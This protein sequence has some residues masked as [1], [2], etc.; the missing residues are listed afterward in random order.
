LYFKQFYLG[1]LAQASYFIGADS[2]AA[3]VD[4]QRDVAQYLDEAAAQGFKIKY[5]IETHLHADF[6]SG[7][8]E[9]AQ[10]TG[11]EIVFGAKA[12]ATIAHRAVK[13]GEEL[14]VGRLRLRVLE[15]PGHTLEGISL[16][17]IDPALSQEPLKA[18]TGDTLFIGDV[19]R[20]DLAGAQGHTPAEMAALLY[21]SLHRKLLALPDDVAVYPAHGAGSL[22]G[23]NISQETT[24]TIGQQRRFN[25]ALQPMPKEQFVQMMTTELPEVPAYF[26]HDV[27]LNRTGATA[28]GNLAPPPALS[29]AEVNQ[30]LQQGSL[31]LD[32]RP[33]DAFGA[34]HI[35][36]ALNIGL[37]GQFASWAGTLIPTA[38]PII[39]VT[40]EFAQVDE[41]VTRLARIGL[42]SVQGYLRDGME[43]WRQAGL[44][45]T[46]IPQISVEEMRQRLLA[47][48]AWQFIDV[49]R[50]AEYRAGHAPAALNAPLSELS[51]SCAQFNRQQATAVICQ[52]G[53]RSSLAASLLARHGFQKLFNVVG[54]TDAWK[55]AGFPLSEN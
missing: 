44:T 36:D 18:L 54:G 27:A 26:T 39:L 14:S 33:A 20:P 9:L 43:G 49:R 48:T 24:S 2:E 41:A 37:N 3:V 19:G 47:E 28:L 23:R 35:P 17:V 4:P 21:D 30:R 25:Y 11:A 1:C 50:P 55:K 51:Q 7:H 22:C 5:V 16:L 29:P 6:V 15:T 52:G 31:L 38:T 13:D 45:V 40:S 32:V 12:H 53:Y 42:E 34:G 8:Q 10:R 46:D